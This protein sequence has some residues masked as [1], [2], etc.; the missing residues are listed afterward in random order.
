MNERAA[1]VAALAAVVAAQ[2]LAHDE[3]QRAQ[4]EQ[5]IRLT[6]R[7]LSDQATAQRIGASGQVQ[8]LAHL[9][10][11]RVHQSLAEDLLARGDLAGAR[12]AAD[13]ALRHLGLARRLV[14]DAPARQA[15]ARARHEQQ[16]ASV[17]RLLESWRTRAGP[18][19]I[20]LVDA[21]GVLAQARALAQEQ[22]YD[23]AQARLAQAERLVLAGLSRALGATTLDYTLRP[24]TPAEAFQQELARQRGFAELVPLA[25][26]DLRPRPEALALVERYSETSQTLRAQAQQR[27]EQGAAAEALEQLRSATLY[28]QRALQAAGLV[29]PPSTGSPP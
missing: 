8:A 7:L 5:K 1:L 16:L 21:I 25:V 9:D 29:V 2:A 26:R 28:L 13:E 11:G 14:P 3:P 22:R 19:G 18:D 27:F 12:Q 4:V 24:A 6:A 20:E 23:E 15:A 17:E 10:E